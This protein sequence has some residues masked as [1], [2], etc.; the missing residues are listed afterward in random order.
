MQT[1]EEDTDNDPVDED[2]SG[3]MGKGRSLT[4]YSPRKKQLYIV[5]GVIGAVSL[6]LV[7]VFSVGLGVGL[8]S[9]DHSKAKCKATER[10]DCL[11][12]RTVKS[13]E[14]L[15][16]GCCWDDSVNDGSPQCFYPDGYILGYEVTS[17]GSSSGS[18]SPGLTLNLSYSKQSH[19]SPDQFPYPG[20]VKK[21]TVLVLFE[22][23]RRLHVKIFDPMEE[24]YEVPIEL[25]DSKPDGN[26]RDYAFSYKDSPFSFAVTRVSTDTVLFDT[27]SGKLLFSDQFLEI[28]S[29]LPTDLVYGLGEHIH[30]DPPVESKPSQRIDLNWKTLTL[31][32][33]DIFPEDPSWNLYG[34]HPFFLAIEPPV[35]GNRNAYGV[36]FLNSNAM[37]IQLQPLPAITYRT[38]GGILDFYFFIGNTP[39]E[40]IQQYTALIGRPFM[41]PYWSLG[42]HLC[43]WGYGTSNQT[44]TVVHEMR[45]LQIPQDVQWNDIDYM[46]DYLDF[47]YDRTRFGSLPELVDDLHKHNQKYIMIVDPGISNT[48][49]A[50]SYYPYDRGL[51]LGIFINVS[52]QDHTPIVGKVWPGYTTFPDFTNPRTTE[53]WTEMIKNFHSKIPFDGLWI[54]MNEPSNFVA[55]SIHG[56]PESSLNDPPYLPGTVGN[57]LYDKTLCM[58]SQ[59]TASEHYNVHSLYG[60]M[61]A[62]ATAKALD[63]VL[64]KRSLVISRSTFVSSGRYAGHWLGDNLSAWKDLA[65]S[66]PGILDFSLFG[67]PMVGADICGFGG[68]NVTE[69]LCI[70]WMEAG[71]FYPFSRNHNARGKNPQDPASFSQDFAVPAMKKALDLRY[72][73]LPYLYTLFYQAHVNGTTVARPLFFEF[74]NEDVYDIGY[75]FMW[76]KAL[77]IAP[78]LEEGVQQTDVVF[79]SDYWYDMHTGSPVVNGTSST[80]TVSSHLG[81][82]HVPI[83]IRGG[84]IVPSF[85]YANTTTYAIQKNPFWLT[86]ATGAQSGNGSRHSTGQLYIDDGETFLGTKGHQYLLIK[87]YYQDNQTKGQL[88]LEASSSNSQYSRMKVAGVDILGMPDSH[89][90]RVQLNDNILS[91]SSYRIDRERKRLRV[92][93]IASTTLELFT[94]KWSA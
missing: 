26:I 37:D 2:D 78:V 70:R 55:G 57:K 69:E 56:C 59:Q 16:R 73:F 17:F 3:L 42:F 19:F 31:F 64:Q 86:V 24:R 35:N 30:K 92:T 79:P 65:R 71:S 25:Q 74:P 1:M 94:L 5:I 72:T 22:T 88:S 77:L 60:H 52:K 53:Y 28:S 51:E 36:L 49:Q 38:I 58:T 91:P 7:V 27:N 89:I 68:Q 41:P 87:M 6:A 93:A 63:A 80:V 15:R 12:G 50:G 46:R 81:E 40:V 45:N 62:K 54:D 32:S 47:T 76:G 18:L 67:I 48:Q 75:E 44:Q 83:F 61:E 82:G 34:E 14:C 10:F 33:R 39:E 66:I 20:L 13:S 29:T 43:R 4:I 23:S 85:Q 90:T 84:N 9:S 21:L 11:P 8:Q